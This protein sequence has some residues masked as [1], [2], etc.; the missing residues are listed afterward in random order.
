MH[1]PALI[2][3]LLLIQLLVAEGSVEPPERRP[4]AQAEARQESREP[5]RQQVQFDASRFDS[6]TA[7]ALRSILDRAAAQGLPTAPLIN[8]A[9]EGAARRASGPKILA[10]VRVHAAALAEASCGSAKRQATSDG[11]TASTFVTSAG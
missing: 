5:R 1:A 3:C 9:L 2:A 10:V 6:L 4:H 11:S 8:R 7:T